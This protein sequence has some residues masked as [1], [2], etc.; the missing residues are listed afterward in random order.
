MNSEEITNFNTQQLFQIMSQVELEANEKIN[1]KE[2]TDIE[3]LEL[4]KLLR[5]KNDVGVFEYTRK[6]V[7]L[8]KSITQRK[9]LD[10]SHCEACF[11]V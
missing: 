1:R 5:E 2:K 11:V 7:P 4:I 6:K 3:V 10:L 8:I 9:K